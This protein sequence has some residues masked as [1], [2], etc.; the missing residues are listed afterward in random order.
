MAPSNEQEW[1]SVFQHVFEELSSEN[2]QKGYVPLGGEEKSPFIYSTRGVA[3]F[4]CPT[5]DR[6]WRS[7]SCKIQFSYC[8]MIDDVTRKVSH[9]EVTF[10]S[11]VQKCRCCVACPYVPARFASES[12]D[13]SL[14]KLCYEVKQQFHRRNRCEKLAAGSQSQSVVMGYKNKEATLR[15]ESAT[16]SE[17]GGVKNS[18]TTI[19]KSSHYKK[20]KVEWNLKFTCSSL[21]SGNGA[22]FGKCKAERIARPDSEH[23]YHHCG[24]DYCVDEILKQGFDYNP[25]SGSYEYMLDYDFEYIQYI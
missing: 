1:T 7:K 23:R 3:C 24:K 14:K 16:T 10:H 13:D 15:V 19:K 25:R 12:I 22:E 5:C 2:I 9:G 8:L 6:H 21:P 17:F 18:N 4:Q 11:C 20:I